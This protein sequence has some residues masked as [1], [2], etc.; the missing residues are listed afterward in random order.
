MFLNVSRWLVFTFKAVTVALWLQKCLN[1]RT[2][3]NGQTDI[4][5]VQTQTNQT[6]LIIIITTGFIAMILLQFYS[7]FFVV[8]YFFS[9][10]LYFFS[11]FKPLI[12]W[13]QFQL[14]IVG[15]IL[16]CF[17]LRFSCFCVFFF[18]FYRNFYTWANESEFIC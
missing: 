4:F 13:N 11:I 10:R 9:F 15:L 14:S 18:F 16:V 2:E 7:F 12:G 3:A 8:V 17:K 6:F 5:A 1:K